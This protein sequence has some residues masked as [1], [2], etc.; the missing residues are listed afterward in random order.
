MKLSISSVAENDIEQI[1]DYIAKDNPR[2]ALNFVKTLYKQCEKIVQSPLLYRLHPELDKNIR[3]CIYRKYIIFFQC[4]DNEFL[5]VRVLH[6]TMDIK[7]RLRENNEE[8]D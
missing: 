6:G 8:Q 5:I 4:N 7:N 2:R 3:A 1:G